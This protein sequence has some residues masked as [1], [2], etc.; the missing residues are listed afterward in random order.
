MT[1][2][3]SATI[4]TV[5]LA[6]ALVVL[7]AFS[8]P[9]LAQDRSAALLE[10]LREPGHFAIMRHALAPGTGDPRRFRLNDCSTQRNLS[11]TGRRQSRQIGALIRAAGVTSAR[12]YSSQWCRC[13]ETA[14][15]LGLGS[16]TELPTLNSFFEDRAQGPAQTSALRNWLAR[17]DLSQP[18]ILVSHQVNVTGLSGVFPS[19]GEIVIMRR[20]P[21]GRL[22][23][24]GR[25]SR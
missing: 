3:L 25:V 1:R 11:E 14:R 18:V 17:A 4:G 20:D 9:S 10:R 7:A 22:S 8:Q 6:L 23:V 24:V 15:L 12:V 19:S 5:L 16:V 2:Y 21:G 13:L